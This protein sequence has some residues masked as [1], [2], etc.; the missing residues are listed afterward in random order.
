MQRNIPRY[1]FPRFSDW[2]SELLRHACRKILER[3]TGFEPA[4]TGLEGR[5]ST[6]ELPPHPFRE[7]FACRAE[8]EVAWSLGPGLNR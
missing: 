6:A 8:L 2:L 1:L 5:D 4:T 3:G 7:L